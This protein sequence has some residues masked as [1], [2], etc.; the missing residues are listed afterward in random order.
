MSE[1]LTLS[2][3]LLDVGQQYPTDNFLRAN[4]PLEQMSFSER[5]AVEFIP[6]NPIAPI[7][8]PGICC[9]PLP[10][11]YLGAYQDKKVLLLGVPEAVSEKL[12]LALQLISGFV[13]GEAGDAVYGDI[14]FEAA[15]CDLFLNPGYRHWNCGPTVA[16]TKIL[17]DRMHCVSRTITWCNVQAAHDEYHIAMEAWLPDQSVWQLLDPHF[18][19]AFDAGY[20]AHDVVHAVAGSAIAHSHSYM[21]KDFFPPELWRN[22]DQWADLLT[23]ETET[24]N[25]SLLN[26]RLNTTQRA[27]AIMVALNQNSA[28]LPEDHFVQQAYGTAALHTKA[29]MPLHKNTN[30]GQR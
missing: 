25:V 12:E 26:P 5:S 3:H 13:T 17:L 29:A 28:L 9:L 22:Y 15:L 6:V 19:I 21:R 2:A 4:V 18:G 16:A 7:I 23:I 14:D 11:I 30:L 8:T 1:K 24:G 10:G 20:S 27:R